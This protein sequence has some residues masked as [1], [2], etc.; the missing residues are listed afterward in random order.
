[1]MKGELERLRKKE[2]PRR[3][4]EMEGAA[5]SKPEVSWSPCFLSSQGAAL[6]QLA[7]CFRVRD[8]PCFRMM[9]PPCFRVMELEAGL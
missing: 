9:R 6:R 2:I 1:M 8:P 5:E 3:L 7:P 4:R